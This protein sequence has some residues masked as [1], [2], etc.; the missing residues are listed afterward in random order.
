MTLYRPTSLKHYLFGITVL[1]VALLTAV[2]L[3]LFD[4]VKNQIQD[5]IAQRSR[6][7]SDVAVKVL[8]RQVTTSTTV[9][10]ER[11][12]KANTQSIRLV[13]ESRPGYE[14]DLGDGYTFKG[15]KDTKIIHVLPTEEPVQ[16][17]RLDAPAAVQQPPMALTRVGD[18]FRIAFADDPD[19]LVSQ[20]IVQFDQH[21]SMVSDYFDGIIIT[22]LILMC[23]LLV[24]FYWLAGK[25]SI[26]LILLGSGFKRL[27]EGEFGAQIVESGV[28][29]VKYT[30]QQFNHMSQKLA[31]LNKQ[32]REWQQQQQLVEIHEVSKG[33]A[34]TLRNPLNTIGLAVEQIAQEGVSAETRMSL[35]KHIRQKISH[36]DKTIKTMLRLNSHD[37]KRD[38]DVD[39]NSIISDLI[40]EFASDNAPEIV[41]ERPATKVKL[42]G[43]VSEV[44]AVI[45]SI[46]SNAMEASKPEQQVVIKVQE[47]Q[48][49][50]QI[51]VVD[52]GEGLDNKDIEALFR[53]HTSDK[54]EGAGMGLFLAQRI[55]YTYYDGAIRLSPNH[56][57]GCV[58]TITLAKEV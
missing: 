26:P 38:N 43:A 34:H 31:Q 1:F 46:L 7:L 20:H 58:A 56:P 41:F 44:R 27:E 9:S 55:S 10:D 57:N 35:A 22:T 15:G 33:L 19:R 40:M 32:E 50:I 39:V 54:P 52:Q 36:L 29:E 2:Q 6:A 37:L 3:T 28:D 14:V 12:T 16:Q 25:I 47:Q 13:V 49:T 4:Y 42:K 45:H 21:H 48:N 23:L 11:L 53:P 8:N 30:L 5:E 17:V 18:S 24:Y 51:E